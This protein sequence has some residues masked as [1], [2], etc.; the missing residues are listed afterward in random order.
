MRLGRGSAQRA[1][2]GDC[3][4][5]RGLIAG[6]GAIGGALLTGCGRAPVPGP[7]AGEGKRSAAGAPQPA[8]T[9]IVYRDPGCGCCEA[10]AG[11]ARTAGYAVTIEDRGDMDQLK[12]RLGVPDSLASC[13]TATVGNYVIEGHVPLTDLA[14]LLEQ[15][16]GGVRGIAVAGM[17]RGSP[18]MEMSDGSKDA[19]EVMAFDAAGRTSLFARAAGT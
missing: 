18:G 8:R 4:T 15:R 11:L 7:V 1:V 6:L 10:W 5:R 12:A 17:P 2:A 3:W 16:P 13:H 14:R 9:M 19:F